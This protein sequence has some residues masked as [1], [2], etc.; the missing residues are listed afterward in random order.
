ML[1]DLDFFLF[2][3]DE[4]RLAAWMPSSTSSYSPST[5]CDSG[6][7]TIYSDYGR[8]RETLQILLSPSMLLTRDDS[9]ITIWPFIISTRGPTVVG[10]GAANCCV[11]STALALLFNLVSESIVKTFEFSGLSFR[12]DRKN[13]LLQ[14]LTRAVSEDARTMSLLLALIEWSACLIVDAGGCCRRLTPI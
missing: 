7:A 5:I 9:F 1:H 13:A 14:K 12:F 11:L 2:R 4:Y 3:N 6:L 8:G 10:S